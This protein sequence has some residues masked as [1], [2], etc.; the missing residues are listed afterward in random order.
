ME[1]WIPAYEPICTVELLNGLNREGLRIDEYPPEP[2]PEGAEAALWVEEGSARGVVVLREADRLRVWVGDL[3]AAA[4]WRLALE[5]AE[6]LARGL[7]TIAWRDELECDFEDLCARADAEW[8][9][10]CEAGYAQL[11]EHVAEAGGVKLR[12]YSRDAFV[13]PRV[14]GSLAPDATGAS[15]LLDLIRGLQEVDEYHFL[16]GARFDPEREEVVAALAENVAYGLPILD[17]ILVPGDEGW[18]SADPAR[19]Y[20][21]LG[22]WV[23]FRDEEQVFL[24]PLSADQLGALY[25][26]CGAED[27]KQEDGKRAPLSVSWGPPPVRVALAAAELLEQTARGLAPFVEGA[28]QTE[29]EVDLGW[30]HER[31]GDLLWSEGPSAALAAYDQAVSAY[32]RRASQAEPAQVRL[33]VSLAK[34]A[35]LSLQVGR[36][37]EGRADQARSFEALVQ[38]PGDPAAAHALLLLL[39]DRVN[40]CLEREAPA[41]AQALAERVLALEEEF[42]PEQRALA[43]ILRGQGRVESDKEAARGDLLAGIQHLEGLEEFRLGAPFEAAWLLSRVGT[44]V[45]RPEDERVEELGRLARAVLGWAEA[46]ELSAF[47]LVD[48]LLV[49]V[50][51]FISS[52]RLQAAVGT[53]QEGSAL[54]TNSLER[55]AEVQAAEDPAAQEAREGIQLQRARLRAKEAD[56]L[57]SL[58]RHWEAYEAALDV[59]AISE[60]KLDAW[61]WAELVHDLAGPIRRGPDPERLLVL[62]EQVRASE[63]G[64]AWVGSLSF[65][66]AKALR[67]LGEREESLAVLARVEAAASEI[68]IP[69]YAEG[70]LATARLARADVLIQAGAWEQARAQAELGLP[71]LE[72]HMLRDGIQ[73]GASDAQVG[74]AN[75]G[76]ALDRLGDPAGA[77]VAW[78]AAERVIRRAE[79]EGRDPRRSWARLFSAQ[80]RCAAPDARPELY[81]RARAALR[82]E[83]DPHELLVLA[84]SELREAPSSPAALESLEGLAE[85]LA[86]TNRPVSLHLRRQLARALSEVPEG[87]LSPQASQTFSALASDS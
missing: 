14:L 81:A 56:G 10:A 70:A 54:L 79:A 83:E 80:A 71:V 38:V 55:S 4:D 40:A 44:R 64:P 65:N 36:E 25:E 77:G 43:W 47:A 59:L 86:L 37:A 46:G 20:R 17:R 6:G 84:L 31:R 49:V 73:L 23:E 26:A 52:G 76:E 39:K 75:L 69:T 57:N 45:E 27:E 33:G 3:C 62:L 85:A 12:A 58:G 5:L 16:G 32:S 22:S 72:A 18:R 63:A 2:W 60:G 53:A 51:G 34:R 87:E 35:D 82:A 29:V 19:V 28:P 21:A 42:T 48:A 74:Y 9:A 13:G 24:A 11:R 7:G 68:E 8:R 61:R 1:L 78:R 50:D 15:A 66:Q 41:E 30:A 67:D